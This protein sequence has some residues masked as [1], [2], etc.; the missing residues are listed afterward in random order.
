MLD[1]VDVSWKMRPAGQKPWYC[2]VS[3]GYKGEPWSAIVPC[4]T[5][6]STIYS[7]DA[8]TVIDAE[9][10]LLIFG[11]PTEDALPKVKRS[12]LEDMVGESMFLP[13][14]GTVMMAVFL[15]KMSPWWAI[16]AGRASSSN[17]P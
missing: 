17:A 12:D 7:Y 2:D 15:N 13:D 14:I 5:Q 6:G 16:D 8:D 10:K 3:Q 11:H 1:L 4:I 9:G